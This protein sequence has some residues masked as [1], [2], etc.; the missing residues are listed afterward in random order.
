MAEPQMPELHSAIKLVAIQNATAVDAAVPS[1]TRQT[2]IFSPH[3]T[4]P[5]SVA[6]AAQA[7]FGQGI[8]VMPNGGPVVLRRAD[9]GDAV[10]HRWTAISK[11]NAVTVALLETFEQRPTLSASMLQPFAFGAQSVG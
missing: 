10:C 4:E 1:E 7:V 3:D 9:I 2:L 8:V 5:Y 6:N 11:T